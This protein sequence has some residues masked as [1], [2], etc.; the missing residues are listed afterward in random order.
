MSEKDQKSA[1]MKML[2]GMATDV[3]MGRGPTPKALISNL[4]TTADALEK[5]LP[6]NCDEEGFIV[7]T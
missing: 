5:M 1:Y 7:G 2:I 3:L 6:E 4:R